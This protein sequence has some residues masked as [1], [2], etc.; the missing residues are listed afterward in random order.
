MNDEVMVHQVLPS[1][2]TI[3][4]YTVQQ[5]RD[6]LAENYGTRSDKEMNSESLLYHCVVMLTYK[7]LKNN[8]IKLEGSSDL[9]D[10]DSG[11]LLG[12]IAINQRCL[13]GIQ[14][15]LTRRLIKKTEDGKT[16]F[17]FAAILDRYSDPRMKVGDSGGIGA[18]LLT[19]IRN[20]IIDEVRQSPYNDLSQTL[21]SWRDSYKYEIDGIIV[22]DNKIYP[23]ENKNPDHSF[24]FK[25]VN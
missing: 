3:E 22:V 8:K 2:S 7:Y 18:A 10:V 5:L 15:A 11:I 20:A 24:A 14:T 12:T 9:D 16:I 6:D 21:L 19:E 1:I 23:R 25:P 4:K 17:G 13:V